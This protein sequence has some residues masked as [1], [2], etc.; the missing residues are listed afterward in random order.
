M[1][2]RSWCVKVVVVSD[3]S[4]F[5]AAYAEASDSGRLM[6]WG[7]RLLV[8]TSLDMPRLQGLLKGYWSFSIINSMFVNMQ[9][10]ERTHR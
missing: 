3:N 10:D 2:L 4:G 7:T 9:E 5:L 6:V 8:V 1:R